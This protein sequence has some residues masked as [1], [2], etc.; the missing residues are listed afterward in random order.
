MYVCLHG[1]FVTHLCGN[2]A[3]PGTCSLS[4]F[5][6]SWVKAGFG[7]S[8]CARDNLP[9]PS[10]EAICSPEP[11]PNVLGP[12]TALI[13]LDTALEAAVLISRK[14][15]LIAPPGPASSPARRP[16]TAAAADGAAVLSSTAALLGEAVTL[17]AAGDA[18]GDDVT[19]TGDLVAWVIAARAAGL[20][21]AV[22]TLWIALAG[23]LSA[24]GFRILLMS[25]VR[26]PFRPLSDEHAGLDAGLRASASPLLLLAAAGAL[27][28][29]LLGLAACALAATAAWAVGD[30]GAACLLAAGCVGENGLTFTGL[31]SVGDLGWST[32]LGTLTDAPAGRFLTHQESSVALPAVAS[33]AALL[34][35]GT[36]VLAAAVLTVK[37]GGVGVVA[38]GEAAAAGCSAACDAGTAASATAPVPE[39]ACVAV[40][41]AAAV[42][43]VA[44]AA[45]RCVASFTGAGDE[46]GVGA[47]AVVLAEPSN[48]RL[49]VEAAAAD[50]DA[51]AA[52]APLLA[53]DTASCLPGC[54]RLA[55]AVLAAAGACVAGGCG[56]SVGAG[57]AASC[58]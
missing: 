17:F 14:P 46:C 22:C 35:A 43:A 2:V 49:A 47:A 27:G 29:R 44:P 13:G 3:A 37:G 8:G 34:A 33:G 55:A 31:L 6:S 32:E 42:A 23:P 18:F 26:L 19:R 48:G 10:S 21:V 54:G 16:S 57:P 1:V 15:G 30:W 41:A 51:A 50:V 45:V 24:N 36:D 28:P 11:M 5:S 4:L 52:V 39:A 7:H 12:C 40:A 25:S 58:V 56:T 20:A 53:S 9:D 38:A